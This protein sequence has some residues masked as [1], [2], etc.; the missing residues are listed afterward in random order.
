[1]PLFGATLYGTTAY[2]VPPGVHRVLEA[3][4][5]A[6]AGVQRVEKA[7][8]AFDA[9]LRSE[10]TASAR[11]EVG[12]AR[13]RTGG[14]EITADVLGVTQS[15]AMQIAAGIQ[16]TGQASARIEAGIHR[17][18]IPPQAPPHAAVFGV[19][20]Y[21][22]TAYSGRPTTGLVIEVGVSRTHQ[23]ALKVWAGTRRTLTG[24]SL[25]EVGVSRVL[26]SEE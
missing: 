24:D 3:S 21:G 18:L 22:T 5:H 15:A 12:V 19:H 14:L 8:I 20:A 13:T 16:S 23:A 11:I 6:E 9:G 2:G 1:M 7:G 10:S 17:V 4:V 26:R 25:V